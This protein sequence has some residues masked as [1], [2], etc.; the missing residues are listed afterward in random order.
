MENKKV[1]LI[2]G[3]SSKIGASIAIKFAK[4]GYDLALNYNNGKD[5]IEKLYNEIK[6]NYDV[7]I[8]LIK[9]DLKEE[10]EI[11]NMVDKVISYYNKIDILINNAAIEHD[12]IFFDKTKAEFMDVLN[13]NLI[14]PFLISQYVSKHMLEKKS[15][16]IINIASTNGIDTYY[17]ESLDYDASKAGLIS[18]THNLSVQLAPYINVNAVAPGWTNTDMN[19]FLD[20]NQRKNI[21]ESILLKR[22]AEPEEIASVVVFLA[23]DEASYINN[24]VIR[25]DGGSFN[26]RV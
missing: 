19:K 14:A 11:K 17:P 12:S 21:C 13:V 18:M 7:N 2:T 5:E 20:D 3:S 4:C 10:R 1:V 24:E 22:F 16:R 26:G 8:L 25:V 9:A 6:K 23:S 15:G